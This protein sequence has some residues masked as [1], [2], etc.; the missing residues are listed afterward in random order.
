[1]KDILDKILLSD[2]VCKSFYECYNQ[3]D[4]KE[5]LLGLLPEVE[6]CKNLK[7]DN[8]WHIYNCLDHILN[9]VSHMNKQTTDLSYK[10]RR[11]LAY[12]MFLHDI[13]KP[14]CYIRRYSKL[15]GREV[16]SFFNHNKASVKVAQKFLPSVGFNNKETQKMQLLIEDHDVFM[17]L[18]LE[19]DGNKYHKQLSSKVVEE[20]IEKCNKIGNG[21]ELLNQLIMVGKA[22][23]LAQNPQ[24]TG[25]SLLLLDKMQTMLKSYPSGPSK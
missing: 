17:F 24:M 21:E 8:P 22:D 6:A 1:M 25:K 2:D 9:S 12:V 5:W 23:N 4:F 3:K 18:T 7:Q 14:E 10:E 19:D 20:R 13:G 15:Y 11:M 16:D